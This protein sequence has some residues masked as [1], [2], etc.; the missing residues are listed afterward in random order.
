MLT[1]TVARIWRSQQEADRRVDAEQELHEREADERD[2]RRGGADRER[3]ERALRVAQ[4]AQAAGAVA[5]G[6]AAPA[7]RPERL[8]QR[9]VDEQADAEAE[10]PRRRASRTAGRPTATTSG[11]RSALTPKSGTCEIAGD[12]DDARADAG[13]QARQAQPR[14][15]AVGASRGRSPLGGLVRT[16]TKS[17]RRRSAN[18]A[19]VDSWLSVPS[20]SIRVTTP[21]GMPGGNSDSSRSTCELRAGA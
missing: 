14:A 3:H 5:D 12:L 16:W 21:I 10:A 7:R 1:T 20:S 17:S 19:Q 18:G 13:R 15:A 6:R 9:D 11:E 4:L 2:R 8:Q